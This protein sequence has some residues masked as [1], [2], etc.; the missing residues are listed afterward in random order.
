MIYLHQSGF[1]KSVEGFETMRHFILH[2][3]ELRSSSCNIL[4]NNLT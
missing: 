4:H 2:T 3:N 1:I